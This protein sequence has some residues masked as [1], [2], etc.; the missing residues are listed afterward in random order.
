MAR[1]VRWYE[2]DR[3]EVDRLILEES[4][5][6]ING[7]EDDPFEFGG[8]FHARYSA[9]VRAL[10]IRLN[11]LY[12]NT[13]GTDKIMHRYPQILPFC[14]PNMKALDYQHSRLEGFHLLD[15]YPYQ[16]QEVLPVTDISIRAAREDSLKLNTLVPLFSR[17]RDSLESL[18]P[19]D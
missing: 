11:D 3:S 5:F 8:D 15:N 2:G 6:R 12:G 9:K 10:G 1:K 4:S 14:L 19:G 7:V 16:S 18:H 13:R 17:S